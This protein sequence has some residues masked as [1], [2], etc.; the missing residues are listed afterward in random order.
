MDFEQFVAAASVEPPPPSPPLL[1][2]CGPG[3]VD[4]YNS[5]SLS[6]ELGTTLLEISTHNL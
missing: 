6:S 2:V 1:L 5:L 4:G 3:T